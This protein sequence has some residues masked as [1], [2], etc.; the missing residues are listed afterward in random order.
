[1]TLWMQRVKLERFLKEQVL[2]VTD[3][4]INPL[5]MGNCYCNVHTVMIYLL[6]PVKGICFSRFPS[7]TCIMIY[8]AGCSPQLC[9]NVLLVSKELT[10]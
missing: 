5:H 4:S 3:M 6:L 9:Y 1:M 8:V 7:T 2:K 10:L